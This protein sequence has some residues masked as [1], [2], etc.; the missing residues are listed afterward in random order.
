MEQPGL[1]AYMSSRHARSKEDW[2]TEALTFLL[3]GSSEARAALRDYVRLE[4]RVELAPNLSYENQVM[5][6]DTGRPDVVGT[7]PAGSDQLVIEA[8][9]WAGLTENQPGGYL[10]RLRDGKPG[11]VLVVTPNSRLLSLWSELLVN[12][13]EPVTPADRRPGNY[14][15]L[16]SSGDV[17]ALRSWR[18]VLDELTSGFSAADLHDWLADLAQLRRLTEREEEPEFQPLLAQ[19]LDMRAA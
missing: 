13:G 2:A 6:R 4:L 9:F 1:F 16:R 8:K 11:V 19:D 10:K 18:V 12:L 17:L 3:Q 5:D 14:E 15:L 7:D